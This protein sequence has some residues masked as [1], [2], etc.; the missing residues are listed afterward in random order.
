MPYT[1]KALT[2]GVKVVC[3]WSMG[4]F[5]ILTIVFSANVQDWNI[6]MLKILGA[7][8]CFK[9]AFSFMNIVKNRLLHLI[10]LYGIMLWFF[11]FFFQIAGELQDTI[12]S[13][14]N[15]G[16]L[17]RVEY[18]VF[19]T[20]T[21]LYLQKFISPIV[22]EAMMFA[23]V[24]Y[25]PLLPL[26]GYLCF[27][28]GGLYA[29]HE[30]LFVLTLAYIGCYIGFIVFPVASQMYFRPELYT[31]PLEG[32]LF[33]WCAEWIRSNAHYP[34][35]SLPSPHCTAATVML[36]IL[37]KYNRNAFYVLMPT[38]LILYIS[39]VYGRFHY[40]WDMTTGISLGIAVLKGYPM[41]L[42]IIDYP[43]EQA[44]Q[45]NPRSSVI[46]SGND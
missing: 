23:Y 26:V 15:D 4:L 6:V 37:Y 25:V 24:A 29:A 3:F 10:L 16:Q 45:L 38:I 34:G 18:A 46:E 13:G 17:L 21:S 42:R 44:H 32:G 40:I 33:T 27:R 2:R 35:G 12:I 1:D 39:T 43:V 30:Y 8:I 19:G 22:T 31:V 14:W 7:A 41:V 36:G 28:K 20:E 9:L 11:D 5:L